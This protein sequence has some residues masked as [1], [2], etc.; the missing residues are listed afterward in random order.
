MKIQV[1]MQFKYWRG[2]AGEAAASESALANIDAPP[3]LAGGDTFAA[4]D[5]NNLLGNYFSDSG[6]QGYVDQFDSFQNSLNSFASDPM[7]SY[8]GGSFGGS[9]GFG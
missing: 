3:V 4:L 8:L 6:L 7:G 2:V 9:L 5:M 1:T